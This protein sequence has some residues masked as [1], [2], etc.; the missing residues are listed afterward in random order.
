VLFIFDFTTVVPD[1]L[2]LVIPPQVI[3]DPGNASTMATPTV[4]LQAVTDR[5]QHSGHSGRL[6]LKYQP[7]TETAGSTATVPDPVHLV[8]LPQVIRFSSP[9]GIHP[10][11]TSARYPSGGSDLS[12]TARPPPLQVLLVKQKQ[13]VTKGNA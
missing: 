4:F 8:I 12:P 11:V 10:E 2:Y 6:L 3:H 5:R 1:P 9:C 13:H 7:Q